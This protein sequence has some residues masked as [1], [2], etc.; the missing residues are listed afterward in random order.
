MARAFRAVDRNHRMSTTSPAAPS[1]DEL[2]KRLDAL[3]TLPE[4]TVRINA[5]VKDPDSDPDELEQVIKHD[6]ALVARVMKVVNSSLYGLPQPVTSVKRAVVMLGFDRVNR[7]AL[8]ASLGHLFKGK[9]CAKHT[10]KDLWTHCIAVGAVAKDLASKVSPELA[11]DAFLAGLT[12]DLG[13]VALLQLMPKDLAAVCDR[14]DKDERLFCEIERDLIGVDHEQLGLALTTEWGFPLACRA[15]AGFHHR[16][17]EAEKDFR[18]V[19]EIVQVADTLCCGERLGFSLTGHRQTIPPETAAKFN[20]NDEQLESTQQR[21][22][23]L[24][25]AATTIF[26]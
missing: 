24:A 19:V 18:A 12:H 26:A 20:L 15:A 14:A 11:E 17:G 23:A 3:G 2:V 9:L 6:P 7:L 1:A 4:V 10:A 25:Y 16:A 22:S 21:V 8:A 5:I 13:I